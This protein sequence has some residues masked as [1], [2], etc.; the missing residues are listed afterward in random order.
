MKNLSLLLVIISLLFLFCIG[1]V[2]VTSSGGY[3]EPSQWNWKS[4]LQSSISENGPAIGIH[5]LQS[6]EITSEPA[7]CQPNIFT[8]EGYTPPA[9]NWCGNAIVTSRDE[10]GKSKSTEI[11]YV[12]GS[13]KT[14]SFFVK[15]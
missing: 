4:H 3:A 2:T 11:Q 1:C 7:P 14:V 13:D 15:L 8:R 12:V 9:G 5:N 6:L 10:A